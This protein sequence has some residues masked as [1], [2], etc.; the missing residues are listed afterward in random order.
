MALTPDVAPDGPISTTWGN[1]IR[2][3]TVQVFANN[4]E[5]DSWATPPNGALCVTIDTWTL[6]F[7]RTGAWQQMTSQGLL[8]EYRSTGNITVSAGGDAELWGGG[9]LAKPLNPGHTMLVTVNFGAWE[10]TPAE[11]DGAVGQRAGRSRVD[12]ARPEPV[13]ADGFGRC[14]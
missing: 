11:P 1:T 5:R 12:P 14:S 2:N 3:R 10:P 8:E 13:P 9:A 7:R 4:A 6:W